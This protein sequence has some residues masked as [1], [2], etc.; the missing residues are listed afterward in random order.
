MT[1][2]LKNIVLLLYPMRVWSLI[3]GRDF[4]MCEP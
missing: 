1:K 2:G 4:A 3:L